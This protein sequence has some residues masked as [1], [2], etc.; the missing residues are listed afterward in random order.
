MY[1]D[2][3]KI[4]NLRTPFCNHPERSCYI[5]AIKGFGK[6]FYYAFLAKIVIA[7][8]LGL[9]NPR[10]ALLKNVIG[11]WS[12]DTLSFCMFLGSVAGSYKAILCTLRRVFKSDSGI[13][14]FVAGFVSGLAYTLE[15]SNR[16]KRLL[17]MALMV[18]AIDTIV[19][20]LDK[21]NIIK[22]IKNFEVYMFGPVISF[23]VYLYFYEKNLFPPGID[24]A[25]IATARPTKEELALGEY[26]YLRQGN[27][28]F[29]GKAKKLVIK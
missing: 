17:V 14:P 25:F 5:S 29:P 16:R 28:W 22:K 21:W 15:T 20:L 19:Q 9:I 1:L 18:R 23:L 24:K 11:L 26:I 3:N 13:I 8:L 4:L 10:K 12:E 2:S 6:N 27:M 7:I